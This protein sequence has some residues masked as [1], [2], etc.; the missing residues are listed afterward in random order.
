MGENNRAEISQAGLGI[1][2]IMQGHQHLKQL[3]VS[4]LSP[5][6]SSPLQAE[7]YGLLLATKLVQ[8]FQV[9]DPHFYTDC[10]LLVSAAREQSVFAALGHWGNR[11][12]LAAVHASPSFHT[13][14]ITHSYATM[15]KMIS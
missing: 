8:L 10:L 12:L 6:A 7:A 2:I 3:H 9:Q 11:H 15:L 4:A 5:P 13:S 1:V 14:S